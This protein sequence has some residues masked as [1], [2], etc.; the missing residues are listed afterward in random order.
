MTT[1]TSQKIQAGMGAIMTAAGTVGVVA[2]NRLSVSAP[3]DEVRDETQYLTQL[4]TLREAALGLILLAT[5]KSAHRRRI[6]S[7]IVGLAAAEGAVGLQTPALTH[8]GRLNATTS[9]AVFCAAGICALIV[10]DRPGSGGR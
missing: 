9:A 4:W 2:P 10:S 1:N 3:K 6:L 8:R 7:V 5:R